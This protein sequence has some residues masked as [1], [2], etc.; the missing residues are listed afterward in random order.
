MNQS[1]PSSAQARSRIHLDVP[2]IDDVICVVATLDKAS[3]IER[4]LS[5]KG[6]FPVDFSADYLRD[7]PLDRLR[8]LFVALCLQSQYIPTAAEVAA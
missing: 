5:F 2:R 4:F 6:P 7:L 3:L 1:S 8:H